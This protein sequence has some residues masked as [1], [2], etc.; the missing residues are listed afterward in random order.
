[1]SAAPSP[2]WTP[3]TP[4]VFA[5]LTRQSKAFLYSLFWF[6]P[7]FSSSS[8]C[9]CILVLTLSAGLEKRTAVEAARDPMAKLSAVDTLTGAG[10]A[11]DERAAAADMVDG[12]QERG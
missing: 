10:A 1:M 6:G 9:S 3:A 8:P 7:P 12:L 11:G 5:V 2:R 4:S